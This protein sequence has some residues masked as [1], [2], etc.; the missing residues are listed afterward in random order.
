MSPIAATP[1]A[2]PPPPVVVR[3]AGSA[4]AGWQAYTVR[5][6][7]TL[8]DIAQRLG[9]T[10]NVLA[11]QNQLPGGGRLIRTG[12]VILVPG[13]AAAA[14]APAPAPAAGST[15]YTVRAGDTVSQIALRTPAT[16]RQIM[17]ANGLGPRTH[18]R[19]GQVLTIPGPAPTAP[20]APA[21]PAAPAASVAAAT[22][23]PGQAAA[24]IAAANPAAVSTTEYRVRAGETVEGI[25]G[26]SG[27]SQASLIKA[28]NLA[29][30]Y[31]IHVGQLLRVQKPAPQPSA[32]NTFAGRTYPDATVA[33][34]AAARETLRRA[35][36]PSREAMR[37]IIEATARRHG[38]DPR[39]ALA[40]AYQESGWDQRQVSVANAVGAMQVIP[41]SGEWASSLVGRR[42]DLLRAEDNATAGVV[43]LRA[44]TRSSTSLEEAIAGYYQGLA[45]V[46]S[47]GMYAD[48]QQYV[49]TI[50]AL[51]ARS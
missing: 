27:V 37:S 11:A 47:N 46:R 19:P 7:D 12:S 13:M 5:A 15:A 17:A 22:A 51:M 39:L 35:G 4:P 2:A 9:T 34:A 16:A 38:I 26:R 36:A 43:I 18:I 44:L 6:G 30:P 3:I 25:A 28:N 24:A 21:T 1:P 42:L 41:S 45:S 31:L 8:V 50:T 33:A 32:A 40:V 14:P 48:T 10:P 23:A 29:A 49:V 20:A